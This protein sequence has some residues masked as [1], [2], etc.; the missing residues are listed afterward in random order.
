MI[1]C[2]LEMLHIR[3]DSYYSCTESYDKYFRAKTWW[4]VWANF[5]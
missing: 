4:S 2:S 3:I 1:D 5:S